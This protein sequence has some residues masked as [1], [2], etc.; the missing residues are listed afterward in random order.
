MYIKELIL[1]DFGKF[2]NKK[3][4]LTK[5]FNLIYGKNEA[6]K[7]TIHSFIE[8][9]FYGFAKVGAKRKIY[10]SQIDKYLPWSGA[11][12]RGV[13]LLDY[14]NEEYR[15]ERSFLKDKEYT[16]VYNNTK[17]EEITKEINLLENSR[18]EQP[19]VFFLGLSKA[20]FENTMYIPQLKI[21]TNENIKESLTD[22]F[23]NFNLS[24]N[25][26]ISVGKS[27]DYL[28]GLLKEIGTEAAK[29]SKLGSMK[30]KLSNLKSELNSKTYK[31][32]DYEKE[33]EEID[34]IEKKINDAKLHLDK[35]ESKRRIYEEKLEH[36]NYLKILENNNI[37]S[38]IELRINEFEEN[39]DLSVDYKKCLENNNLLQFHSS[40]IDDLL[41]QNKNL[42]EENSR[43]SIEVNQSVESLIEDSK[44]YARL[45]EEERELNKTN[46]SKERE[47]LS[48][49][50][51]NMENEKRKLFLVI[52]LQVFL[53]G[54][55]IF[56]SF[57]FKKYFLAL[58]LI[59]PGVYIYL[60]TGN[61][62]RKIELI[63]RLNS[64]MEKLRE[65]SY[66]KKIKRDEI[67]LRTLEL[68]DKYGVSSRL[69]LENYFDENLNVIKEFE[70][71]SK[72]NDNL[73]NS[74][75]EKINSL[76]NN[77]IELEDE[78]EI[79]LKKYNCR[80]L[81]DLEKMAKS[82]NLENLIAE[83]NNLM[84]I[85]KILLGEVSLSSLNH[86]ESYSTNIES[87]EVILENISKHKEILNELSNEMLKSEERIYLLEAE[88]KNLQNI[89][90]E[91]KYLEKEIESLINTKDEIELA[92][93]TILKISKENRSNF[94]PILNSETSQILEE[95]TN[96][97]Y[98]ELKVDT[99][100]EIRVLDKEHDEYIKLK[101]LS[102]G[103]IDQIYLA[104]RLAI[105]KILEKD[106]TPLILDDSFNQYDD[107][108]LRNIL[109]IL[110]RLNRQIILFTSQNREHNILTEIGAEFNRVIL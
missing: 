24:R 101:Y 58:F 28:D 47:F 15:I 22:K 42:L 63:K 4:S 73:I 96:G 41:I 25:E 80:N 34:V 108:R 81:H 90:E 105:L 26:N 6:G 87:K 104:F 16:K 110:K 74:N 59:I 85:N 23:V 107:Y 29:K 54:V 1:T 95:I 44:L 31:K 14:K 30:N 50:I 56:S 92:K 99:D 103:T 19:G 84:E 72:F 62:R 46:Y 57:I 55:I 51:S 69:E 89:Q 11:D 39:N 68:F 83:K 37:I 43:K 10:T 94:A 106:S 88:V 82:N 38:N 76:S 66:V 61:L 77:I 35:W 78:I 98:T 71:R 60:R 33:I 7:S 9:V 21:K 49:D 100:N 18:I 64:Q 70:I 93:D 13:L 52:L 86:E 3:I 91:I 45:M 67:D 17:G 36:E 75:K 2:K 79:L 109:T 65:F 48:K 53:I 8:G 27:I 32:L 102:L 20:V 5:N 40:K 97:K 12:Y